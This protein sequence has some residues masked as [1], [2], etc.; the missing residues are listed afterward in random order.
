MTSAFER[1]YSTKP[2]GDHLNVYGA[3]IRYHVKL[4]TMGR[5]DKFDEHALPGF[6]VGPSPENP[7]EKYVWTGTR[8]IS[9]GGSFVIDESRFLKPIHLSTEY[10]ASWPVRPT[11]PCHPFSFR[12]DRWPR[13]LKC[14]KSPCRT[15]PSWNFAMRTLTSLLMTGTWAKSSAGDD[16]L[17]MESSTR[18]SVA[19]RQMDPER[20]DQLGFP[21]AHLA[22]ARVI[23]TFGAAF[24]ASA[25]RCTPG[26]ATRCS[27]PAARCT[28]GRAT[29]CS[30]NSQLDA[31][32]RPSSH[33]CCP[34]TR[35]DGR[36]R[37]QERRVHLLPSA[38]GM[39]RRLGHDR[40]GLHRSTRTSRWYHWRHLRPR[41]S[42]PTIRSHQRQRAHHD[43]D[44]R[45]P[46]S[47]RAQVK[48][49]LHHHR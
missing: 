26:R 41:R 22:G 48:R 16:A 2:C 32:R 44:R 35:A 7:E 37:R 5:D 25:T 28:P 12:P 34:T 45:S 18:S 13:L 3:P 9:V 27:A 21:C 31:H 46:R 29:R 33:P 39:A 6:Y 14:S 42:L 15:R 47:G 49:S 24:R 40:I 20:L 38:Q 23:T 8:H 43:I 17:T 1:F 36:H 30:C 10:F 11:R 4:H 19:R